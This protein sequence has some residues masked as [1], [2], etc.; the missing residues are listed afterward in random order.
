MII[1]QVIGGAVYTDD[2]GGL[3]AGLR[4]VQLMTT[5]YQNEHR[6]L[7]AGGVFYDPEIK[8]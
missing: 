1:F 4:M 2:A 8:M 6:H 3:Q 7:T 5:E